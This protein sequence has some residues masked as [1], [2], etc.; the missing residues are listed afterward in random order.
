MAVIA[1]VS[2]LTA[3]FKKMQAGHKQ[4]VVK[5]G[6]LQKHHALRTKFIAGKQMGA[7]K[8]HPKVAAVSTKLT[9]EMNEIRKR[10]H[11]LAEA[12]KAYAEINAL[13]TQFMQDVKIANPAGAKKAKEHLTKIIA[14]AKKAKAMLERD[15]K[16]SE[17][18][19]KSF[20]TNAKLLQALVQ[21]AGAIPNAHQ[22]G[23]AKEVTEYNLMAAIAG[24]IALSCKAG[25]TE[26]GN[27]EKAASGLLGK[28]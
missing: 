27:L 15:A 2:V 5:S 21:A 10:V 23:F 16:S 26:L 25:V 19:Q 17:Q 1:N 14:I 6:Q 8:A 3:P 13:M 18:M 12:G 4:M 22:P 11:D 24:Q 7:A 28:L 20:S 9:A